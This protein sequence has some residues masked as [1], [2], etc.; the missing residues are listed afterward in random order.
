MNDRLKNFG[1]VH[2]FECDRVLHLYEGVYLHVQPF[3][4]AREARGARL[5]FVCL[6]G[7]WRFGAN[8]HFCFAQYT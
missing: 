6:L 4:A 1:I 8:T 2:F 3:A 5:F 7:G